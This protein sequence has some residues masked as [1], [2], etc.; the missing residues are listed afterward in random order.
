MQL[1]IECNHSPTL[2]KSCIL[3]R[4]KFSSAKARV[5]VCNDLGSSFGDLCPTCLSQGPNWIWQ[6][7]RKQSNT[8]QKSDFIY[9]LL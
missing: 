3:C 4:E 9:T 8:H 2:E 6:E 1:Q 5:I 7:L